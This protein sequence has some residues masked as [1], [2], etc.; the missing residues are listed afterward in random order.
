MSDLKL[1][2]AS[3]IKLSAL[4]QMGRQGT[5]IVTAVILAR[6]LAPSDFGLLNMALIVIGF[7]GVFKDL[8]TSSAL[9]QKKELSERLCSS[10]FWLNV[11]FGL[12][13]MM[14]LILSTPLAGLYYQETRV[15]PVLRALSISFFVASFGFVHQ[16]LLERSLS[17]SLLARSEILSIVAGAIVGISMALLNAGVWSLVFQ[18]LMT[19]LA[20]TI[21]LWFSS[22]WRPRRIF[23]WSDVKSV[24]H[25]SFNLAGFNIFNYFARNADYLLI[26]RYLGAQDLGVYTL[27]YRILLFPVQNISAVIGRVMYPVLSTLQNNDEEFKAIYLKIIRSIAFISFPLMTAAFALAEPL[28]LTVFGEQWQSAGLLIMILAP[29]GL[30]QSIG[31]TVGMI[32][33]AKGRTDWMLRWGIGSGIFVTIAFVIGLRWGITGVALAYLV[34]VC[35]LFYPSFAIPFRLVNLSLAQLLKTT[36]PF[37]LNS[38]IL[39]AILTLCMP[40]LIFLHSDILAI[41][42][43]LIFG[44]IGY[45]CASWVSAREQLQD[46][47][48]LIGVPLWAKQK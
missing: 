22:S 40:L 27:A 44:M 18:T 48:S 23:H 7:A 42:A 19:T 9:I 45:L 15:V 26:G 38:G 29:V 41:V 47:W 34:A 32:Y 3:G 46:L 28:T 13:V 16:A 30:V 36:F 25:F 31:T 5:Q 17:F 21:L 2:T 35:I 39:L 11:V 8:G 20:F 43:L 37:I 14:A 1:Q 6:V 12:F 24:S 4:S 33:Q 10:V